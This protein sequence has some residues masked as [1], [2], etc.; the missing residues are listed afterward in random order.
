MREVGRQ[1][2]VESDGS[3]LTVRWE[4]TIEHEIRIGLGPTADPATH[5]HRLEVPAGERVAR[6]TDVPAGRQ[7][8]SVSYDGS[9]V[10]AAERRLRFAGAPNFRD[11]G[12][13][14]TATGDWTRWGVAFRSGSL[15][16]LTA[17]DLSAFDDLGI[18]TIIDLR[19]DD[20]RE[21][22]PGQRPSRSLPM[23]SRY[24]E[25]PN[26]SSLRE[27][28]DGERWLFD[29]YQAM[30]KDGGPVFGALLASLADDAET[31]AV[32]HCAGGKDRTGLS[33]AFLLSWL[34]VDRE[35]VLD[36]YELTGSY[37]PPADAPD[38]VDSM[39]DIGI[40]RSAAEGLL[41]TPR[42][43]LAHALELVDDE[44]GGVEA[45][46]RGPAGL[47]DQ[48]LESLRARLIV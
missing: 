45:Y 25:P 44:Y 8:V 41:S 36:D 24:A 28:A 27:R 22:Q 26:M 13:Y 46:L 5:T 10:V 33:A 18:R 35:T 14:P 6:L 16:E 29:E 40:G 21:R 12:G 48:T 43:I 38:I 7:Y 9:V 32:F 31:P 42:W 17:D 11:L 15:H 37:L 34:G 39:V 47:T 23:P 4:P 3:G 2:D 30:L 20:E 19:R 1:V